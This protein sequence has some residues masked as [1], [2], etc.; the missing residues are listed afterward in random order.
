MADLSD[1]KRGHI[2]GA[3][4]EGT[5]VTKTAQLYRVAK[6]TVSK[7][8]K[9]V[10]KEWKTSSLKQNSRRKRK[11]SDRD[12]WNL[13]YIVRKDRKNT[14]PKITVELNDH[15]ENPVSS[16]TVRRKL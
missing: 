14:A 5:S 6:S 11:L 12:Y 16:K 9:A 2:I 15:F 1:I 3:R 8:M 4:M 7:I 10:E 13:T